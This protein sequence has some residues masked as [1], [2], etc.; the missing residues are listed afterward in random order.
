MPCP[1]I[2]WLAFAPGASCSLRCPTFSAEVRETVSKPRDFG[3]R[4][5]PAARPWL[6]AR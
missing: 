3:P 5:V 4:L 6:L 1:M 2:E